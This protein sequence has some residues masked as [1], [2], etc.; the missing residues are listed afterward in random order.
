MI[1]K[2]SEFVRSY[3]T[4]CNWRL[5]FR[6]D[7][8]ISL[9]L[10]FVFI[11]QEA[12]KKHTIANATSK[13]SLFVSREC[14]GFLWC[15]LHQIHFLPHW[16]HRIPSQ[17]HLNSPFELFLVASFL[18]QQL[19]HAFMIENSLRKMAIWHKWR[20]APSV[21]VAGKCLASWRARV[22]WCAVPHFE[23]WIRPEN[24]AIIK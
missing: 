14:P 11:S 12:H 17:W 7:H 15:F 4:L 24:S 2:Q 23:F 18:S 8:E 16:I 21:G 19:I 6:V 20:A 1:H 5:P 3:W 9:N 10:A 22:V 13:F